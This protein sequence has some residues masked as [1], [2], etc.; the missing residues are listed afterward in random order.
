MRIITTVFLAFW[1]SLW[2]T[3]LA[4]QETTEFT[5]NEKLD[6]E[7]FIDKLE[8]Q[9]KDRLKTKIKSINNKRD[10]GEVSE[11]EALS[12]K[13]AAAE[14]SAKNIAEIEELVHLYAQLKKRNSGEIDFENFDDEIKLHEHSGLSVLDHIIMRIEQN[15]E[16]KEKKKEPK[17]PLEERDL[18]YS[19]R[20]SSNLFFAV[21]FNNTLSDDFGLNDSPFK[22][23]GSRSF[24]IGYEWSTRVFKE[25]NFLRFNYGVSV[26]FNGLKPKNNSLLVQDGNITQI[27]EATVDL[28]K[29]KFRMDN[30]ILPFHLQFGTSETAV[31]NN[32]NKRFKDQKFIFG[33]GGFVGV[34]FL[35]TQKI[36][37]NEDGDNIKYRSRDDYNTNNILYG[38]SSYIGW[39]SISAFAQYNLNPIFKDNPVDFHNFQI[40]VRV[41]L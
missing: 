40:G 33:I 41:K 21:S 27:E 34:N 4:A 25:T 19:S 14:K 32:G 11:D 30:L 9:E 6:I 24:E 7:N 2:T 35:N 22:F 29:S 18:P 20:T 8:Q 3:D 13:E 10:E 23:A 16:K 37:Y 28:D 26:Q 1:L 38:L 31:L 5:E 12:Q 36:K 39:G 15:L 17:K